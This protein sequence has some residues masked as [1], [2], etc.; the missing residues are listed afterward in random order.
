MNLNYQALVSEIKRKK[1]CLCVGLDPDET[2]IPVHLLK[3][4]NYLFLFCKSI[5]DATHLHCVSFKPNTA[6]F[7]AHGL[8]GWKALMDTIIYIRLNYPNH[9]VIADAKRGDI[10][11]TSSKYAQAFFTEM[12]AHAITVAPY[13]GEDSI[14]PFLSFENRFTIILAL[15]SN[16][17]ADN[18]QKLQTQTDQKLYEAVIQKTKHWGTHENTMYVVGATK[19]THL[20]GI[21]KIIPQHF[22]LVPGV[23]AQGGSMEEVMKHGK[24]DDIGLLI[25]AS[26]SILYADNTKDFAHFAQLEAEKIH[27][28]MQNYF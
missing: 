4:E 1:S 24:T 18:F 9:F 16:A 13:M 7:E 19:A 3:E 10:G 17:G 27:L 20:I 15:T 12:D 28:D 11:N 25:N 21:R 8:S 5:I 14:R 23:G 6:F 26:R 2:K 22:L